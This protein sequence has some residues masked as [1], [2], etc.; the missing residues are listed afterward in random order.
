MVKPW[1]LKNSASI[2]ASSSQR[3]LPGTDIATK[4][5]ESGTR[6]GFLRRN[7]RNCTIPVKKQH[8]YLW[9]AWL[10]NTHP[11]FGTWSA[12][13]IS[14]CSNKFNDALLATFL[15]ITLTAHQVAS[16]RNCTIP[17]KKQHTKLW[18]AWLWNTHPYFGTWSARSIS[19]CSKKGQRRAASYFFNN[20]S[21][22]TPSCVIQI[23]KDL[24]WET[25]EE[26]RR[27]MH[28]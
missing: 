15:T 5:L 13:S 4:L 19:S 8:T 27:T 6:L 24:H 17:V 18:F 9:P 2:F 11:Y 7:F 16:Y 20:Y 21:D 22:C 14:S 12:R 1:K 28:G 26:G 23:V 25:L 3:T 10:W